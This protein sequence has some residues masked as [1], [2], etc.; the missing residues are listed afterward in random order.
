MAAEAAV[1]GSHRLRSFFAIDMRRLLI[2]FG[3]RPEHHV[4]SAALVLV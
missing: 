3:G 4:P 2:P 1:R